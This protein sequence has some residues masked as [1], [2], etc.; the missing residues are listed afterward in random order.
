MKRAYTVK[1]E[2]GNSWNSWEYMVIADSAERAVKIALRQSVKD[3]GQKTSDGQRWR[4]TVL[5]ER[6]ERPVT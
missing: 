2:L 3:S 5:T 1:T 6:E 4:V